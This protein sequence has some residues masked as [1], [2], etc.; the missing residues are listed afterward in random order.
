M[1]QE[2]RL[3]HPKTLCEIFMEERGHILDVN[4]SRQAVESATG[5]LTTTSPLYLTRLVRA[6][7]AE[8][9]TGNGFYASIAT[10]YALC[11]MARVRRGVLECR[12]LSCDP[13]WFTPSRNSFMDVYS[14]KITAS[15]HS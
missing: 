5:E 8:A 3:S 14:R 1:G 6:L 10:H 15:R 9:M 2:K 4:Q 12:S 13:M 11:N 7:N